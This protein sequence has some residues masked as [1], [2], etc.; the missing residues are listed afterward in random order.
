ML[1]LDRSSLLLPVSSFFGAIFGGKEHS[2]NKGNHYITTSHHVATTTPEFGA[3]EKVT[4]M[5][6]VNVLEMQGSK[7]SPVVV[8]V[9][10]DK[11]A[12]TKLNIFSSNG[13]VYVKFFGRH[14]PI[15]LSEKQIDSVLFV[16]KGAFINGIPRKGGTFIVVSIFRY[17]KDY[18]GAARERRVKIFE[19]ETADL[20]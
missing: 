11:G 4:K 17:N 16:E 9:S 5:D 7:D 14:E 13:D 19:K 18:T 10:D 6:L 12:R 2:Y 20:L 8:I 3:Y 1:L 15:P